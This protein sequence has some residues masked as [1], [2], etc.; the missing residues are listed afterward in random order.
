MRPATC[1][2]T[3]WA[4]NRLEG[5]GFQPQ[6]GGVA[7]AGGF[8]SARDCPVIS[9]VWPAIRYIRP[10]DGRPSPQ[11]SQQALRVNDGQKDRMLCCG[12]RNS[13]RNR[14]GGFGTNW[15]CFHLFL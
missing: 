9:Q 12:L 11:T 14:V 3:A 15:Y 2:T 7:W 1:G 13:V 10:L 4:A 8:A 5:D 6:P